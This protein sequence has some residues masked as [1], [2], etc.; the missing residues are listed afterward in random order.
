M[1]LRRACVADAKEITLLAEELGYP[2]SKEEMV[3]RLSTFLEMPN[4]FIAVATGEDLQVLGW[5]AAEQRILLETGPRAE[6]VGL[7]VSGEIRRAGIGKALVRE[8]ENWAIKKGLCL[9]CV[10]SNEIRKGAHAFYQ[11]LGY[12]NKKTQINFAKNL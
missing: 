1:K 11:R 9:I 2:A 6:I 4:S 12:A 8:A 10:R 5:I 7:I 3:E